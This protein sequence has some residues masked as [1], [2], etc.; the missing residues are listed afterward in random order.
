LGPA[1]L[2]NFNLYFTQDAVQYLNEP[3][4]FCCCNGNYMWRH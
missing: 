3:F 1:V 4:L 2:Q